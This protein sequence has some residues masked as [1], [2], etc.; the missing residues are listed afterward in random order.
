L[1]A[2]IGITVILTWFATPLI[3]RGFDRF[4]GLGGCR[5]NRY[6][7]CCTGGAALA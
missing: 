6:V 7:A 3:F 4:D 1:G 2:K 5:R